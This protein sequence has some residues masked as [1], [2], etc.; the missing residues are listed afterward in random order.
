MG[1]PVSGQILKRL[2]NL[3]GL[4][5]SELAKAASIPKDTVSRLERGKQSGAGRAGKALAKA[6]GVDFAVLTGDAKVTVPDE[7]STGSWLDN[8]THPLNVRVDGAV[9]NAYALA[10]LRYNIPLARIVELAPLLFVLAAER[11][12][13][14]RTRLLAELDE[15]L[16]QADH[17][18]GKFRHLPYTFLPSHGVSEYIGAEEDSIGAHDLLAETVDHAS[19]WKF[20]G[21]RDDYE[22]AEHNPFVLSLREEATDPGIAKIDYFLGMDCDFRICRKDAVRIADGD[23]ELAEGILCGHVLIHEMPTALMDDTATAERLVWLRER[24]AE[25]KARS[26]KLLEELGLLISASEDASDLPGAAP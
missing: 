22:Q 11:S 7:D 12:L 10:A 5:Q 21:R 3:R 13:A 16:G 4:S 14:R 19:F 9:R 17:I 15:A 24:A 18:A 20:F 23:L 26:D 25:G 2:R 1:K 6:L 8:R